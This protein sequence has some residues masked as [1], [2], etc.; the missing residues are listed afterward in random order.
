MNRRRIAIAAVGILAAAATGLLATK[1]LADRKARQAAEMA[2]AA[3]AAASAA[4]AA[5]DAKHQD[6]VRNHLN[7]PDSAVFRNYARSPRD[8]E[9]W[10][11]EINAR[12]RMGGMVG[13]TRYV[14]VVKADRKLAVLDDVQFDS[15]SSEGRAAFRGRWSAMCEPWYSR[16]RANPVP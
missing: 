9:V 10:C 5:L 14:A 8:P 13:F 16:R 6:A 3:A 12:N 2:A 4:A 11:G 15:R 1:L 7:D